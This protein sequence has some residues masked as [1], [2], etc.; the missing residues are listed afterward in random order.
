M[1]SRKMSSALSGTLRKTFLSPIQQ[2]TRTKISSLASSNSLDSNED[3]A[4]L[5]VLSKDFGVI[6][7]SIDWSI[8]NIPNDIN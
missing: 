1:T 5:D 7:N 8:F 2:Q 4:L 6:E 3:V